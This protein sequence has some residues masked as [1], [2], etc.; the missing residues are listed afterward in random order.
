MANAKKRKSTYNNMLLMVEQCREGLLKSS[1]SR[2]THNRYLE[3]NKR[4][5]PSSGEGG[6]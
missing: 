4:N 3:D 2:N 5:R 6:S 1:G